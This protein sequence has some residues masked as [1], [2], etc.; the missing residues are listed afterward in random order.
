[1]LASAHALFRPVVLACTR[2]DSPRK[3]EPSCPNDVAFVC[4][5]SEDVPFPAPLRCQIGKLLVRFVSDEG[6]N[7][8]VQVEEEHDQ[9]E[10]KL[11]ER[12]LVG[13]SRY[14]VAR[15]RACV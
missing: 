9:V 13:V 7:H 3:A 15:E 10:A 6:D 8:A 2:A 12:L 14:F 1:M 5:Q 11:D 4:G